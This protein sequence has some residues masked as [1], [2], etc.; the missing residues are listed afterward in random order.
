MDRYYCEYHNTEY[1]RDFDI[2]RDVMW[3]IVDIEPGHGN[4]IKE[5]LPCFMSV[6]NDQI[7]RSYLNKLDPADVI[8]YRHVDYPNCNIIDLMLK[9]NLPNECFE[10]LRQYISDDDYRYLKNK[11]T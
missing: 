1:Y 7:F 10:Q 6:R 2:Y 4:Y 11:Y 5:Q 8:N 3:T 9:G